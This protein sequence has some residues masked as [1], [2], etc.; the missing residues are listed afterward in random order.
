MT[1]SRTTI[2]V[3]ALNIALM[4]IAPSASAA[5][6]TDIIRE[7][8]IVRQAEGTPPTS[9]WVLYTRTPASGAAF[10]VGPGTAPATS[11]SLRLSTPS[12]TDKVTLFH[13]FFVATRLTDLTTL[14]YSTYRDPSSSAAP[15]QL[16]SINLEVDAN[17]SA[18]GGFTT[19]VFEP[20]YN[21]DQGAVTS[22]AWQ[23]WD[24]INGGNAIWWSTQPING[25][26]ATSCYVTWNQI[27]MLNPDASIIG[28]VGVNQGSGNAGLT[29]SV[30]A[31]TVGATWSCIFTFDFEPPPFVPVTASGCR[32]GGWQTLRRADGT[33]F[34]NQGDCVQYANRGK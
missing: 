32:D 20:V 19:L 18:A 6:C 1:V 29:A 17:G 5:L 14:G 23:T 13:Y 21:G 12:A 28:G 10:V 22:G 3:A 15:A 25:A 24:A 16:P 26:C 2:L 4:A 27:L 7:E 11:G 34:R 8:D 31:L 33:S 9:H 30:D